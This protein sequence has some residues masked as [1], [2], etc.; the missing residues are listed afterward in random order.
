VLSNAVIS[1]VIFLLTLFLILRKSTGMNLGLAAGIGVRA[2]I[3]L[4]ESI[5]PPSK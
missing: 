5:F 3:S 2:S 1:V 4:S